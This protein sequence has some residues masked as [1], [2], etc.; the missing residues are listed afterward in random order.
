MRGGGTNKKQPKHPGAPSAGV[1]ALL[2]A[3]HDA[4]RPVSQ[5]CVSQTS[6]VTRNVRR[7]GAGARPSRAKEVSR[8]VTVKGMFCET[9]NPSLGFFLFFSSS[10]GQG[11]ERG[12][13]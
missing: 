12:G 3:R 1:R 11:W 6:A 5:T 4:W 7:D 2:I 13:D 8:D 10:R 9:G